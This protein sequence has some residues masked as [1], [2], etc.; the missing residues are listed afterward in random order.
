[1]TSASHFQ[2]LGALHGDGGFSFHTIHPSSRALSLAA[3]MASATS[4]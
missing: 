2:P 4:S 3:F 1:M